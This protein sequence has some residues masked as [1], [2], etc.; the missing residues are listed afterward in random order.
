MRFLADENFRLDVVKWL[1]SQGHDVKFVVTGSSD[2][3]VAT[4]AKNEKRILLTNDSDFAMTL[5]FPPQSF[6]GILIFRIHPPTREKFKKA[7]HS[8]LALRTNQEINGR[9]FIIEEDSFLEIE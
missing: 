3:I 7:I 4:L 2:K 6:D 8:F 1:A 9:T 5:T